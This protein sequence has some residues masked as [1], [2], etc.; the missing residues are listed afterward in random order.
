MDVIHIVGAGGIGC[1][2]G[3]ALAA[4]G[5]AVTFIEAR[6]SKVLAGQSEGVRVDTRPAQRATF[7]PFADWSPPT[8]GC[9]LLCTKCYDNAPVLDRVPATVELIPIQNGFDPLLIAHGHTT[10]GIAS[11]VSECDPQRPHTRITRPG[12]LHL[13]SPRLA[14]F[15]QSNELFRV[16]PVTDIG[17]IKHSK[18]MYNAAISPLAAAAGIDNGKLLSL[19]VARKLFFGLLQENH[20]ILSAADL[21]LGKVGPFHPSTVAWILRQ[22]WLAGMM[23]KFFEPSLRGTYCSMA[24]EIEKGRTEIANYNGYLITLAEKTGTPCPL[25]HAVLN[26]VTEMTEQRQKP[27]IAVL[28]SLLNGSHGGIAATLQQPAV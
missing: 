4:A 3:Y 26:L 12:E 5:H 18:L 14:R 22:R 10:E 21:P 13:S 24:G 27:A 8:S 6:T 23:A 1:A 20:R 2:V 15:L 28:E 19:P 17:P 25:N 7:V 11:F 9:V 16:V